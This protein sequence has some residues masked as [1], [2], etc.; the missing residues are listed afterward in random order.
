MKKEGAGHKHAVDLSEG[1]ILSLMQSIPSPT[2]P[3]CLQPH[4]LTVPPLD[5]MATVGISPRQR[6]GRRLNHRPWSGQAKDYYSSQQPLTR[7][8]AKLSP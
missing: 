1:K 2:P 8:F 4:E 5:S 7:V 6:G 3:L